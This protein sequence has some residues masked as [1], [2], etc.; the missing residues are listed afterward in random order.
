MKRISKKLISMFLVPIVLMTLLVGCGEHSNDDTNNTQ[1]APNTEST[2]ALPDS[3]ISDVSKKNTVAEPNVSVEIDNKLALIGSET[4]QYP[5]KEN[6]YTFNAYE[7]Y[8][9]ITHCPYGISTLEIPATI[10]NLPVWVIGEEAAKGNEDLESV[11]IPD[12]VVKICEF[13]FY[14]AENLKSIQL[15][16]SVAII[17]HGAFYD[18]EIPEFPI[19]ENIRVIEDQAFP[20]LYQSNSITIPESAQSIGYLTFNFDGYQE[21]DT[22]TITILSK[23]VVLS[24]DF[25][26]LFN[27]DSNGNMVSAEVVIC[28]YAGST[29]AAYCAEHFKTMEVIPE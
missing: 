5:G 1:K 13:A 26:R 16:N 23:N 25:Y 14:E 17:E 27:R 2:D 12:T 18:T 24:D 22:I 28:G 10:N 15:P 8:V 29:A 9:E 6:G 20:Y 21:G 11:I 7:S 19:S 3:T 4:L